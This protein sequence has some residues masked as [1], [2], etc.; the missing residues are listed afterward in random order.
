MTKPSKTK[1]RSSLRT[2]SSNFSKRRKEE[3]E[4]KK[5]KN[6]KKRSN[7]ATSPPY[8][9]VDQLILLYQNRL[10]EKAEELA[11]QLSEKFPEYPFSRK[12]LGDLLWYRNKKTE[13]IE[14]YRTAASIDPGDASIHYNLGFMAQNLG[15]L[16]EARIRYET[17]I[18]LNPDYADA[19]NNLGGIYQDMGRLDDA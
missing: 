7:D 10:Y 4:A 5:K 1:K 3:A 16:D 6:K 2:Q 14:V 11:R 15:K 8:A 18:S 9:E 12:I 19:H 17:A 13:A